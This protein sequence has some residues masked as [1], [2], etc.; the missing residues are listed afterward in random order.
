MKKSKE[1][2]LLVLDATLL[3][4]SSVMFFIPFLRLH[5]LK[6]ENFT[7]F[8]CEMY[9]LYGPLMC[10]VVFLIAYIFI[11]HFLLKNGTYKKAFL[12]TNIAVSVCVM[13]IS[14][15]VIIV[16]FYNTTTFIFVAFMFL[17]LGSYVIYLSMKL[18]SLFLNDK[19]K[20]EIK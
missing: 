10:L 19:P 11:S 14:A 18:Y 16:D 2:S 15:C 7:V 3:F 20:T 13:I 1:I 6:N 12:I 9:G 8:E 17:I 4:L 5:T